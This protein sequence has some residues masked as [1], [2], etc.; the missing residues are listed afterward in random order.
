[1]LLKEQVELGALGEETGLLPPVWGLLRRERGARGR[2]PAAG[3]AAWGVCV[4][5]GSENLK[6]RG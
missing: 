4:L 5:D 6:E 2:L 3:D 1:M